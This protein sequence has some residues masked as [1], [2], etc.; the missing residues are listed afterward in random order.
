MRVQDDADP[1]TGQLIPQNSAFVSHGRILDVRG[2]DGQK[3][4]ARLIPWAIAVRLNLSF[5]P[6]ILFHM[7]SSF[8]D[9]ERQERKEDGEIERELA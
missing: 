2:R 8:V 7:P 6:L 3:R 5:L 4:K 9:G 1:E